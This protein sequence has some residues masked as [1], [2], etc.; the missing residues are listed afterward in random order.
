MEILVEKEGRVVVSSGGEI[1]DV[2]FCAPFLGAGLRIS[3]G[4]WFVGGWHPVTYFPTAR[5]FLKL[6][7]TFR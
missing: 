1:Q 6:I 5:R 3:T 2:Q 7:F 4:C